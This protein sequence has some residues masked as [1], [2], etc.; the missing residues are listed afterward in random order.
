ME[1]SNFISIPSKHLK[2]SINGWGKI[3]RTEFGTFEKVVILVNMLIRPIS[4]IIAIPRRALRRFLGM[5]WRGLIQFEL[6]CQIWTYKIIK[7]TKLDKK[8]ETA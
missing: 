5:E 6:L 1:D 7:Y 2:T 8:F 4:E 3:Y